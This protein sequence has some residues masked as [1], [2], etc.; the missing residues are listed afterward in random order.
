[1][2][3]SG[4]KGAG[5]VRAGVEVGG[6]VAAGRWREA[7]RLRISL[8]EGARLPHVWAGCSDEPNVI[9]GPWAQATRRRW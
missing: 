2:E 7:G 1:M 9:P 3:T 8:E 5:G 4:A 6:L